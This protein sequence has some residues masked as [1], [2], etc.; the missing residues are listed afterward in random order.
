MSGRWYILKK[1]GSWLAIV[2]LRAVVYGRPSMAGLIRFISTVGFCS[3]PNK[4]GAPRQLF[5]YSVFFVVCWS[6]ILTSHRV[7]DTSM[8]SVQRQDI[9][10]CRT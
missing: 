6:A 3:L 1:R 4:T 5:C 7:D 9:A 2:V 8:T 10:G